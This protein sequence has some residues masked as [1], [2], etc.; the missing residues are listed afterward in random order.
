MAVFALV[1]RCG[2]KPDAN[3]AE[4]PA[5]EVRG[6]VAPAQ[7][8]VAAASIDGRV[9][10]VF[11]QEGAPVQPGTLVARIVNAVIERDLAYAKAQVAAAELRLRD[12]RR[13]LAQTLILGDS[14]ARE[15]AS[16]EILKN[17]ESKRDR[18]RELYASRDISKQELEDAENEYASA[19]RDWLVERERASQKV[20]QTDTGVLQLELERAK[21]EVAFA[22]ERRA[23]LDVKAPIGGVV[24]R[25][26]ARIGESIF[27]RDPVVEIANTATVEVRGLIAPELT[28]Y[29]RRGMPVEAK[30]FTVPPRRFT[31]PIKNVLPAAGGATLIV[32]LPNPDGVLQEGQTAVVTVK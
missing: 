27:T 15:R 16:A 18:Y 31:V 29:V 22:T 24:T 6:A 13:P 2:E 7:M 9:A 12:A 23:L 17:R 30:V 8:A 26:H 28:R 1:S 4:T 10:E 19:L 25:V 32:E 11:V 3:A 20:I 14:G 5:L 21:A